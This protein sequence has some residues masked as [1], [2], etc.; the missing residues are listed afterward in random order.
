MSFLHGV[1]RALTDRVRLSVR[2]PASSYQKEL[3]ELD[4]AS[5]QDVSWAPPFGGFLGI[6]LNGSLQ[7]Y[8]KNLLPAAEVTYVIWPGNPL[9]FTWRNCKVFVVTLLSTLDKQKRW[10]MDGWM[11]PILYNFSFKI[12]RNFDFYQRFV[13]TSILKQS[14]HGCRTANRTRAAER[15]G[16]KSR[17][18]ACSSSMSA[19]AVRCG[20]WRVV[21]VVFLGI[22]SQVVSVPSSN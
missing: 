6:H 13:V 20:S 11:D 16:R 17:A 7:V 21:A 4:W 15:T 12:L 22:R 2:A 19:L 9:G 18:A 8:T 3:V 14:T 5:D 10:W 1:S